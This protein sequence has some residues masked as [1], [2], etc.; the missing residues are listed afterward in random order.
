M[1][2]TW[3]GPATPGNTAGLERQVDHFLAMRARKPARRPAPAPA[4]FRRYDSGRWLAAVSPTVDGWLLQILR[5]GKPVWSTPLD[6][7]SV[8]SADKV[9]E[10]AAATLAVV[11]HDDVSDWRSAGWVADIG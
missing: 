3:P 5:H 1:T 10:A 6:I 7:D 9:L 4:P 11:G 2:A 8:A